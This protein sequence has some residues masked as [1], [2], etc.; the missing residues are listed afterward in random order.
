MSNKFNRRDFLTV[1]AVATTGLMV[2]CSVAGDK[3]R[4]M[5][6]KKF[7]DQAPDGKVLKAG[8]IGCGGRG[9]GAAINFLS[10]GPNLKIHSLGD[11]LKNL[12]QH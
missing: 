4:T 2:G 8:L 1:G 10:A 7:M 12:D 9:T 6:S 5:K 11:E 3:K